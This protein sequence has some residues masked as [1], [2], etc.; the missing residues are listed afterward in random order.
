MDGWQSPAY[1][2][3]L[4]RRHTRKGI[5]GSNPIPSANIECEMQD[6]WTH[7]DEHDHLYDLSCSLTEFLQ[8]EFGECVSV[9]CGYEE[10]VGYHFRLHGV[11]E[12]LCGKVSDR[13]RDWLSSNTPYRFELQ[14]EEL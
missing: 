6:R 14:T 7:N 9:E 2:T 11:L 1:C 13:A 5:V 8:H 3:D 12:T 4:E 10:R